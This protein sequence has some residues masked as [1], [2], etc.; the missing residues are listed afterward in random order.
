MTKPIGEPK[1]PV[2]DMPPTDQNG[3]NRTIVLGFVRT[4]PSIWLVGALLTA[5]FVFAQNI[6]LWLTVRRQQPMT[7]QPILNLLENCKRQMRVQTI[8]GVVVSDR[9]KSPALFGFIR[10]RLLLP[11]GMLDALS[12]QELH[13]VFLH[14]LAHLKRHDI[15][16]GWMMSMLQVLHWFNP[17]V[18]LASYR[19]RADRELACDALVLART[20]SEQARDYGRTIVSLL[21]R[22]S[23]PQPL[24]SMA[25]IL[26][27]K[28]Q[29]K[30]RIQMIVDFKK[31][32]RTRSAG[33]MLV[34]AILAGVVLTNAYQA[35]AG[36]T[37]DTPTN[38][39]PIVNSS[40]IED[41]GCISADG[42]SLYFCS[43]RSG[44]YGG[45]DLW[46]ATRTSTKDEW[47]PAVNLGPLINTNLHN[48]GPNISADGLSL[49]FCSG[50]A[51]SVNYDIWLTTRASK[52]DPWQEP[53]KLGPLVNTTAHEFFPCVSADGLSLY[54]TS[55][56]P[57]G[58]G[59]VDIWVTM[60]ATKDDNW[61]EPV[62]L[63][64]VVNSTSGEV[65]PAISADELT[66]FFN[67]GFPRKAGP[68]RPGGFGQS[69]LWITKRASKDAPWEEPV[70]LGP[71]VNTATHEALPSISPDG[72]TLYF[73]G[74]RPGG[75]GDWDIWQVSISQLVSN[76]IWDIDA[77]MTEGS[78]KR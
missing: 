51:G 44:G 67:S 42:L 5:C 47:G 20:E 56:R 9:V 30:R 7:D 26:E 57:G 34:F 73:S 59:G 11:K 36:F 58:F 1:I 13:H 52:N 69:D 23:C 16:L 28:S 2:S 35:K 68:P 32:S 55:D 39:G 66:L 71:S 37:L 75:Y 70:N 63:G 77:N 43:M 46:V 29:V 6:N 72:S 54:F 49:Y 31:T 15:Y 62:N 64:P 4:L 65:R 61:G 25:G 27:T 78:T 14:E 17:L 10:P 76:P 8:I 50:Q 33:A 45:E 19:I 53:V 22:F 24:P 38:M 74:N 3:R 18:W 41:N 21:E 60:R 40:A 12:L 48:W